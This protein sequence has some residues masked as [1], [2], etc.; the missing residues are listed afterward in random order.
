MEGKKAWTKVVAGAHDFALQ[1]MA[2]VESP[3]DFPLK[4][5]LL[6]YIMAFPVVL[7]VGMVFVFVGFSS[8]LDFFNDYCDGWFVRFC[9]SCV[10]W[11]GLGGKLVEIRMF[12]SLL[13]SRQIFFVVIVVGLETHG[14]NDLNAVSCVVR[15]RY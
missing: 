11:V 3:S 6:Q 9:S 10:G 5:A 12:L 4:K 15:F 2:A 1:V 14:L 7:K 8:S 13:S